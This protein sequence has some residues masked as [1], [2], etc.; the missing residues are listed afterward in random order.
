MQKDKALKRLEYVLAHPK[1]RHD[2]HPIVRLKTGRQFVVGEYT[3]PYRWRVSELTVN[4]DKGKNG[5][6]TQMGWILAPFAMVVD[7]EALLCL[8]MGAK[9]PLTGY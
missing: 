2:G 1:A 3:G 6:S 5:L 8:L 4:P 7:T 9:E